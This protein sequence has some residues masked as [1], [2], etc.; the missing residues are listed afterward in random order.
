MFPLIVGSLHVTI[1]VTNIHSAIKK[2]NN[3]CTL[4]KWNDL[5]RIRFLKTINFFCS[6]VWILDGR[7]INSNWFDFIRLSNNI[8]TIDVNR[9]LFDFIR[10]SNNIQTIDDWRQSN[11]HFEH[12]WIFLWSNTRNNNKT[13]IV[14][15]KLSIIVLE[16]CCV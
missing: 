3:K 14:V 2:N 8:Q 9:L 11:N 5:N 7:R 1:L 6:I 4:T 10:L 13:I 16:Y 12:Y 15:T